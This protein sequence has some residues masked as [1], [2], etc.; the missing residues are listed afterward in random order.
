MTQQPTSAGFAYEDILWYD[1][2]MM[3]VSALLVEVE[4][5]ISLDVI[6]IPQYH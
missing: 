1:T 3:V 4:T 6:P 5:V 2:I